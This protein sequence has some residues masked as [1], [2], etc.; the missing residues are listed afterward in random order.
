MSGT[1]WV[2][3]TLD[4]VIENSDVIAIVKRNQPAF[5]IEEMPFHKDGQDIPSFQ[6]YIFLFEIIDVLYKDDSTYQEPFPKDISLLPGKTIKV[7][8]SDYGKRIN[9]HK[10]YYLDGAMKTIGVD[11][12]KDHDM[13]VEK[14]KEC[15][16]FL[17]YN[18][19]E[20]MLEFTADGAIETLN[21]KN[22]ILRDIRKIKH[23]K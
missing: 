7:L 13:K 22:R 21:Q 11:H 3:V 14:T 19:S 17:R 16:V 12:Y 20:K 6:K 9:L 15:I 2:S 10:R 23:V 8:Q 5:I 18:Q 1:A 4:K